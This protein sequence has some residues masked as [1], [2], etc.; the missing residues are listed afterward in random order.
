[1]C[2]R[3]CKDGQSPCH[4]FTN[5]YHTSQYIYWVFDNCYR[6]SF[7]YSYRS[8]NEADLINL[9]YENKFERVITGLSISEDDRLKTIINWVNE[10]TCERERFASKLFK[11]VCVSCLSKEYLSSLLAC[12]ESWSNSSW[13]VKMLAAVAFLRKDV[14]HNC[15][16][17][18]SNGSD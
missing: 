11:H 15:S 1:M 14:E 12:N 9:P 5:Q 3:Q 2:I 4:D 16:R 13:F 7:P 18:V 6:F 8:L 10:D 17:K